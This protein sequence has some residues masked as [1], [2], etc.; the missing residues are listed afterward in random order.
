MPDCIFDTT[1]LSNLAAVGRLDWLEERY[2]NTAV[3]TVEVTDELR[4]GL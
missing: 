4:K 2:R 3:A 1:V